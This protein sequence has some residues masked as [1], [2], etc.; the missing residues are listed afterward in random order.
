V[1]LYRNR[2][3]NYIDK[4]R[5]AQRGVEVIGDAAFADYLINIGFSY[6]F[7]GSQHEM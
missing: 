3:Q 2:V 1:A 5:T 6:R 4:I 7:G